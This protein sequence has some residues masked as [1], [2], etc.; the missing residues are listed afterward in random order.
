MMIIDG[1]CSIGEGRSP[2]AIRELLAS[3]LPP[4]ERP[5]EQAA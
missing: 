3:H 2:R 1:V 5:T 4:D